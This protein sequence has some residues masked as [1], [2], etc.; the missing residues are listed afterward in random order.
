MSTLVIARVLAL[1][2]GVIVFWLVDLVIEVLICGT[3][4]N[5]QTGLLPSMRA[6]ANRFVG[7]NGLLTAISWLRAEMTIN[8]SYGAL[9]VRLP[10]ASLAV[11][12]LQ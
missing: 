6:T 5:G 7:L 12:L 4:V 10:F 3:F 8:Y 9:T 1:W 2:L 11:T